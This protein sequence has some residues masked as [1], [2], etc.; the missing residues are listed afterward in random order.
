MAIVGVVGMQWGDEGKGKIIDLLTPHVQMVIRCQGGA[1][2]GHTVIVDEEKYVFH[3]IPSGILHA[4]T[5]CVIGAGVVIDPEA[6]IT[7]IQ[8]LQQRGIALHGRLSIS[9]KA[10]VTLPHHR[11]LDR[12]REAHRGD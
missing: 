12:E 9:N 10:H 2:A 6:L 8:D 11:L 4:G 7:E 1:N 5:R 3:Q